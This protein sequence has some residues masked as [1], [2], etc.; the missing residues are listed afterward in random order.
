MFRSAEEQCGEAVHPPV[1]CVLSP[2]VGLRHRPR[3]MGQPPRALEVAAPPPRRGATS[4][5]KYFLAPNPTYPRQIPSFPGTTDTVSCNVLDHRSFAS[6]VTI[7]KEPPFAP[8]PSVTVQC[9]LEGSRLLGASSLTSSHDHRNEHGEDERPVFLNGLV[10]EMDFRN[11]LDDMLWDAWLLR[12]GFFEGG[13]VQDHVHVDPKFRTHIPLVRDLFE[14]YVSPEFRLPQPLPLCR[15]PRAVL[16]DQI[17]STPTLGICSQ[18]LYGLR[19]AAGMPSPALTLLQHWLSWYRDVLVADTITL[20]ELEEPASARVERLLSTPQNRSGEFSRSVVESISVHRVAPEVSAMQCGLSD[21]TTYS[22]VEAHSIGWTICMYRNRHLDWVLPL[23]LDEFLAPEKIDAAE[24]SHD[25]REPQP[26]VSST[27]KAEV[28][29]V[30]SG[31]EARGVSMSVIPEFR[32]GGP[33]EFARLLRERRVTSKISGGQSTTTGDYNDSS[34]TLLLPSPAE[35]FRFRA[36]FPRIFSKTARAEAEEA[37]DAVAPSDHPE[38]RESRFSSDSVPVSREEQRSH[39]PLLL[40]SDGETAVLTGDVVYDLPD[41]DVFDKGPAL[42]DGS[43][44]SRNILPL[45]WHRLT[46]AARYLLVRPADVV[47]L[48]Q[49][50]VRL[51]ASAKILAAPFTSSGLVV[52]HYRDALKIPDLQ[53]GTGGLEGEGRAIVEGTSKKGYCPPGKD[54]V[55]C[56]L[57]E[58]S[59]VANFLERR[60]GGSGFSVPRSVR[61]VDKSASETS[62]KTCAE[63]LSGMAALGRSL[64]DGD[65]LVAG[66]STPETPIRNAW[67]GLEFLLLGRELYERIAEV[68]SV[69]LQWLFHISREHRLRLLELRERKNFVLLGA[70]NSTKSVELFRP[71]R[72]GDVVDRAIAVALQQTPRFWSSYHHRGDQPGGDDDPVPLPVIRSERMTGSGTGSSWSSS[73][74]PGGGPARNQHDL[75]LWL[76]LVLFFYKLDP[77]WRDNPDQTPAKRAMYGAG[78]LFRFSDHSFVPTSYRNGTWHSP[79]HSVLSVDLT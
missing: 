56:Y 1:F 78:Y 21:D 17:S 12:R 31:L 23:D 46:V 74:S 22:R 25:E 55:F 2:G 77:N 39:T 45:Q 66:A 28:G 70:L 58:Q 73:G 71:T 18:A 61:V 53:R 34:Q 38:Q 47:A 37:D 16:P 8:I 4:L 43:G 67:N 79:C 50:A 5:P 6:T 49:K 52:N 75:R 42:Y 51:R 35:R 64:L 69:R 57:V 72:T 48:G 29:R 10:F 59:A 54:K 76:R 15:A 26:L 9:L 44:V 3:R 60:A 65:H 41:D 7:R 32:F 30:L 33:D 24:E 68:N 40:T 36:P 20:S 11:N 19:N 14:R 27:L 13:G 63:F 62:A